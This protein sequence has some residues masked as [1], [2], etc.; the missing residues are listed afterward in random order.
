MDVFIHAFSI[1]D[2]RIS[3]SG[4]LY[5]NRYGGEIVRNI[6]EHTPRRLHPGSPVWLSRLATADLLR[7][8]ESARVAHGM[9]PGLSSLF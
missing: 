8:D 5:H 2:E 3:S 4:K 9:C 7:L 6:P 1:C